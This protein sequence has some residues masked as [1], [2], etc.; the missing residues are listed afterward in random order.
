MNAIEPVKASE[1]VWGQYIKSGDKPG[2]LDDDTVKDKNSRTETFAS[3]VLY[4]DNPRWKGVPIILVSGK[5][6]SV[7]LYGS[8]TFLLTRLAVE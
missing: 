4:I 2:Y 1:A 6:E 7:F 3:T 8:L 5:G